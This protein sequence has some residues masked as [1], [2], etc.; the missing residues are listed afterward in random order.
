MI[1]NA[2]FSP[3]RAHRLW[4]YRGWDE[5]K[6]YVFYVGL[7]PSKADHKVDDMT[8]KKGIGFA[9]ILGCG[10][11]Y[12]ANAHSLISTDP[13]RLYGAPD[14]IHPDTDRYLL[15]LA[16]GAYRLIVCWG[17]FPKFDQRFNA[18]SDLLARYSPKCF[19]RTRNGYP[20]HISRIA[21]ST[22]LED[23]RRP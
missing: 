7:N 11:A 19:G 23:W 15:S 2:F 20:H 18:V 17:A 1:R 12:F 21:Y 8:V 5:R 9:E 3:D 16:V 10:S 4:L 13:K 14:A 22:P 6:P